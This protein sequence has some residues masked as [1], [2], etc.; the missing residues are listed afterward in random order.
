M[1]IAILSSALKILTIPYQVS[2]ISRIFL[3]VS[4][5]NGVFFFLIKSL[6][7]FIKIEGF[8][9]IDIFVTASK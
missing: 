2:T 8:I 5:S 7:L 9:E 6:V 3:P 4:D 1:Q